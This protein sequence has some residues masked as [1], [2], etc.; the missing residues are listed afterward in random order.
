M[1]SINENPILFFVSAVGLLSAIGLSVWLYLFMSSYDSMNLNVQNFNFALECNWQKNLI[2]QFK[3]LHEKNPELFIGKN[4]KMLV[5]VISEKSACQYNPF[6]EKEVFCWDRFVNN[7]IVHTYAGLLVQIERGISYS[8]SIYRESAKKFME[9]PNYL[10]NADYIQECEVKSYDLLSFFQNMDDEHNPLV[11]EHNAFW[12]PMF[13]KV[14]EDILNELSL[15][16]LTD[17]NALSDRLFCILYSLEY[18]GV[19][20]DEILIELRDRIFMIPS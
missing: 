10:L 16:E 7:K 18:T 8:V 12:D 13:K 20:S 15:N 9:D 1:E 5:R 3:E 19:A 2:S 6:S 4:L 17:A 11:I 14:A